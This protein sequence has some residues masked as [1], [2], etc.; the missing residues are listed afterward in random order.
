MSLS[1]DIKYSARL[2]GKKPTFTALTVCIVAV[3]L[4]LTYAFSLLNGLLFTPLSF[5][6]KEPIYAV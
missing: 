3:G 6:D 5:G 4:G 1:L 2:L